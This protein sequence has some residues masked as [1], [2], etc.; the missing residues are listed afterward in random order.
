MRLNVP[1]E[2]YLVGPIELL[3]ARVETHKILRIVL[4]NTP[5]RPEQVSKKKNLPRSPSHV[6]V[7]LDTT[8][9]WICR[10]R[11][12]VGSGTAVTS[13]NNVV[14][15]AKQGVQNGACRTRVQVV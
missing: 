5:P 1:V 12:H 8:E 3:T 13:D 2:K 6:R 7:W 9:S 4:D 10:L 11:V 14:C 15:D